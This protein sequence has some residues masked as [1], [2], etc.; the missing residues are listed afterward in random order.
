MGERAEGLAQK[1][2]KDPG[3]H[4]AFG[5]HR[6]IQSFNPRSVDASGDSFQP[7]V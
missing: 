5:D 4:G 2:R 1:L 3:E 6:R 7:G